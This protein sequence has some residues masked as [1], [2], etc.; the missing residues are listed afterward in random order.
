MAILWRIYEN[1][2]FVKYYEPKYLE[3]EERVALVIGNGAYKSNR[4]ENSVNDSLGMVKT[5]ES[6]GF[7]VI[8]KTNLK[9]I[10]IS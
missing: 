4:L 8:H 1:D 6:Y 5:L 7:K 10:D 9:Q 2:I 3:Q